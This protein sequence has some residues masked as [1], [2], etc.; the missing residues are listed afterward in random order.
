MKCP[1]CDDDTMMFNKTGGMGSSGE[2]NKR[3]LFVNM[4]C[5]ECNYD[6]DWWEFIEGDKIKSN[7]R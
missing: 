1:K 2:D 6:G 4:K 5:S 3:S 7:F